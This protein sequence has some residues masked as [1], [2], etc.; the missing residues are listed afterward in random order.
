MD[1]MSHDAPSQEPL[2]TEPGSPSRPPAE[3][4]HPPPRHPLGHR[5]WWV[6]AVAGLAIVVA[7]AFS[8][9]PGLLVGPLHDEFGWSHGSI[10]FAASVN[11]VLYGVTAPFAAALMDRFGIRRVVCAALSV[12]AAGALLTTVM[13]AAWQLILYWG[14]LVGLGTGSMAMAFGATVTNRW[15]MVSSWPR[16]SLAVS[17]SAGST[18]P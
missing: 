16:I 8:T 6:A 9:M 13:T 7:G 17:R 1:R 10:G 3:D 4:K 12:I 11:M 18:D 5:A 2:L 14:L 15:C